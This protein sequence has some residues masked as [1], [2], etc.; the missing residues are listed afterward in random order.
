M[1]RLSD[2]KI[3]K[4]CKWCQENGYTWHSKK[5]GTQEIRDKKTNALIKVL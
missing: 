2:V 1:A 4:I 5:D 3:A